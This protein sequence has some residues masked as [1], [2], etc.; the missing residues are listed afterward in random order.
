MNLKKSLSKVF[1]ANFFQIISSTIVGIVVPAILSIDSYANYKTYTLIIAYLGLLSFGF[2]DGLYIK[3]GGKKYNELDKNTFKN[4]FYSYLLMEAIIF[5]I[6]ASLSIISNNY[7]LFLVSLTILPFMVT[8]FFKTIYQATGSFDRYTKIVYIYSCSYAVLNII[9]ALLLKNKNYIYYCI[10]TILANLI[11][12]IY[13]FY[14]LKKD[15]NTKEKIA[16]NKENYKSIKVGFFILLGN[17]A[18]M[19]FFGIDRWMVKIFM[20][21]SDFAYYSFAVNLLNIII[22]LINAI[23]ITFYSYLFEKKNMEKINQIKDI[24]ILIGGCIGIFT[25]ALISN[26]RR[27]KV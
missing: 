25:N 10:V 22:V 21:N 2:A 9:I 12:T 27:N 6:L 23:S 15:F 3:Y 16:I 13:C 20:K 19:L 4:E 8:S 18:F 1:S 24:L 26:K 7:I 14:L 17:L 5:I 11:S